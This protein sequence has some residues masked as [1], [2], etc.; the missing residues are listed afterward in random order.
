M[1]FSIPNTKELSDSSGSHYTGSAYH[2]APFVLNLITIQPLSC[3][4]P[5]VVFLKAL[6]WVRRNTEPAAPAHIR[7][8]QL[9]LTVT[10]TLSDTIMLS[11][12][13]KLTLTIT[14]TLIDTV[15]VSS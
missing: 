12:K 15:T 9:T 10:L 14:L 4:L 5:L 1:H 3:L 2:V 13:T 7:K 11:S 8:I 6:F